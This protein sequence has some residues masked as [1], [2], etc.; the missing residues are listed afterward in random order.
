VNKGKL[1]SYI[2]LAL[3][4]I[5][6]V[7]PLLLF[8]ILLPLEPWSLL[9]GMC[10]LALFTIISPVYLVML[11]QYYTL[12]QDLSYVIC[13]IVTIV[14]GI[15]TIVVMN[16]NRSGDFKSEI[17]FMTELVIASVI[18]V[19]GMAVVGYSKIKSKS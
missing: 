17:A 8:D 10:I 9:L 5:V 7:L 11:A 6:L 13:L 1:F 2:V 15:G 3:L 4:P 14:S 18:L 16:L 12:K 19:I